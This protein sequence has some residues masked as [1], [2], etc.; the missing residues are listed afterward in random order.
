MTKQQTEQITDI[1]N[2]SF[3]CIAGY[4]TK[5]RN[6]SEDERAAWMEN[7]MQ[8]MTKG[9]MAASLKGKLVTS[10]LGEACVHYAV[11][12]DKEAHRNAAKLISELNLFIA[13]LE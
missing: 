2:R 5:Y 11:T 1:L 13:E 6:A 10:K 7:H 4:N 8:F 12:H 3:D 9:V